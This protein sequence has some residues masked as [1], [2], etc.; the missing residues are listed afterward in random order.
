M[1]NLATGPP[2]RG[3]R[4]L[5]SRLK[6]WQPFKKT[7]GLRPCRHTSWHGI[8]WDSPRFFLVQY[9][10]WEG[11]YSLKGT[12]NLEHE[13]KNEVMKWVCSFSVRSKESKIGL[14]KR[15]Q[16]GGRCLGIQKVPRHTQ[17]W[18]TL[19][20]QE[21]TQLRASSPPANMFVTLSRV[22]W[23]LCKHTRAKTT[24]RCHVAHPS[25]SPYEIDKTAVEE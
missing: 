1:H 17:V 24:T 10:K 11:E 7:P 2:C 15:S 9:S 5:Y 23:I 14:K 16:K 18:T 6:R 4:Y 8:I 13:D 20:N 3:F 21:G 22:Q 19:S 12:S 25:L